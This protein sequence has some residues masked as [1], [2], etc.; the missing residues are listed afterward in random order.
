MNQDDKILGVNE[1]QE[2]GV[3]FSKNNELIK[4]KK[5]NI[6]EDVMDILNI[7]E[8]INYYGLKASKHNLVRRVK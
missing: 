1:L 4:I 8:Q 5:I 3:Y 7:S 6:S 2:N